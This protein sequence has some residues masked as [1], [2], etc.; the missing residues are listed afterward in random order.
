[1]PRGHSGTTGLVVDRG[2]AKDESPYDQTW[3]F[4]ELLGVSRG[5]QGDGGVILWWPFP[6]GPR[7][8][9]PCTRA[10]KRSTGGALVHSSLTVNRRDPCLPE[11]ERWW[12]RSRCRLLLEL[13]TTVANTLDLP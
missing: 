13:D 3:S 7:R 1:M 4:S 12:R 6:W 11:A 5:W 9:N 2:G 8:R 10:A